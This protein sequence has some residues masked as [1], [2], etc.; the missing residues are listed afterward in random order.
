MEAGHVI[1]LIQSELRSVETRTLSKNRPGWLPRWVLQAPVISLDAICSPVSAASACRAWLQASDNNGTLQHIGPALP[2][3]PSVTTQQA[4]QDLSCVHSVSQASMYLGVTIAGQHF[5]LFWQEWLQTRHY[6]QAGSPR[7]WFNLQTELFAS[8]TIW[9]DVLWKCLG[10]FLLHVRCY[11]LSWSLFAML[12]SCCKQCF[13]M[14]NDMEW[15]CVWSECVQSW[16]HG[17]FIS[18]RLFLG[19][20]W[21]KLLGLSRT[22]FLSKSLTF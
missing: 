17:T 10:C 20:C 2:S 1:S 12:S 3:Y 15:L 4:R 19:S 18:S 14:N 22:K 21:I 16:F 6:Y 7:V 5:E 8:Q 9:H 11:P 13:K